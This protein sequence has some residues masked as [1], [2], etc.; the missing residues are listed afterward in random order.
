MDKDFMAV[1]DDWISLGFSKIE[2]SGHLKC[3]RLTGFGV[4]GRTESPGVDSIQQVSNL[5]KPRRS[6]SVESNLALEFPESSRFMLKT[7][8]FMLITGNLSDQ[9]PPRHRKCLIAPIALTLSDSIASDSSFR[10]G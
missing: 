4:R 8:R 5:L 3:R 9:N 1:T 10:T 6:N 2:S 7:T